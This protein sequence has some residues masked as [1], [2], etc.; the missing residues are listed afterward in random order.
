MLATSPFLPHGMTSYHEV[1]ICT[2]VCKI[3]RPP[4]LIFV[5]FNQCASNLIIVIGSLA[6]NNRNS[7]EKIQ[8]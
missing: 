3:K 6:D 2:R 5:F 7:T 1:L 8:T 4:R